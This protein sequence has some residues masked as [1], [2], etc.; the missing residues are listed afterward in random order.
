[1]FR[2]RD[3]SI[4]KNISPKSKLE[5]K[6]TREVLSEIVDDLIKLRFLYEE[7][8]QKNEIKLCRCNDDNCGVH[9]ISPFAIGEM[10]KARKGVLLKFKEVYNQ[11]EMK[12][13]Y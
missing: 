3:G 6:R 7:L 10:D 9:L 11:F 5:D 8:I 12:I 13:I 2:L 4:I 1:M